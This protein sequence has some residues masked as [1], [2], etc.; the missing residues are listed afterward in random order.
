MNAEDRFTTDRTDGILRLVTSL[1]ALRRTAG[2]TQ[3]EFAELVNVPVNTL[4]MWDSGLRVVPAP[5]LERAEAALHRHAHQTELVSLRQLAA[6][7]GIHVQTL[8]VA[9][10]RGRLEASFSTRSAFGRPIRLATRAAA[11]HFMATC[12]FRRQA[13]QRTV[14][15]PAVPADY[16]QRLRTLRQR[17]RLSQAALALRL[18]AAGKA[19]VYQWESRKRTPS[20]VFWH[21]V[22]AL[23]ASRS[24]SVPV[25][26]VGPLACRD[27]AGR[28]LSA[29]GPD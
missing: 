1:R 29:A 7:L 6:E 12:Y 21:R 2:L 28:I 17:L 3:T 23:D 18:G 11:G 25:R 14:P 27:G 9:V 5:M 24:R 4:K 15:L 16:D 8:Q 22:Q 20:P 10:R 19:V 26:Q 13:G